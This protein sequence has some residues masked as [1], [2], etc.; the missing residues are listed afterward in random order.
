MSDNLE[1][2]ILSEINKTGFPL[3]LRISDSIESRGYIKKHSVYYVDDDEGKGRE[4]DILA[5]K[6]L[7]NQKGKINWFVD[8]YLA[9]ECKKSDKPWVIFTSQKDG[10]DDNNIFTYDHMVQQ[11]LEIPVWS[12]DEIWETVI[13]PVTTISPHFSH[14]R[15]GR[16]YF[17]PFTNSETSE[18]IYKSLTT[19][20]KATIA[21]KKNSGY[22]GSRLY[23][24]YPTVVLQGRL[25][26]SY[27]ENGESKLVESEMLP[28]SFTYKSANYE[29][30]NFIVPIV[31]E[32]AF[33]K[34]LN[35]LE[36]VSGLWFNLVKDIVKIKKPK[37]N[38]KT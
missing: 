30:V 13:D 20:V 4:L 33:G 10:D 28:V 24:Y 26:E 19:S 7:W 6:F 25:F 14:S 38:G 36:Q 17:I 1:A 29:P 3:E 12:P 32:N 2:Q 11:E 15:I 22:A 23:F 21:I 27:L 18:M 9:I 35:S 8:T 31:T 16:T 34:Y 37:S 5:H